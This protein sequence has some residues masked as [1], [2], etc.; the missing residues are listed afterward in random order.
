[1]SHNQN[2]GGRGPE[3]YLPPVKKVAGYAALCLLLVCF[4]GCSLFVMAG[5]AI[6]G[7]PQISSEFRVHTGID[8]TKGKDSVLILCSAPHG[9]LADFPALQIDIV[10]RVSR[11]LKTRNV[12]VIPADDVAAWYDSHGE[13][14][15]F[16]ALAREFK[17][18]YVMHIDLH[19]FTYRVPDSETV[20]QG[21]CQGR[22]KVYTAKE[23]T[24]GPIRQIFDR[25][26]K[27]AFPEAYPV[28]RENHSD[29][30]FGETFMDR[31]ALHIAQLIYDHRMAETV[32]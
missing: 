19:T 26:L 32:H 27:I 10:D 20:L 3:Q 5:K 23:S 7:D 2:N 22:V 13:W 6:L 14:G 4:S 29:S 1:M 31:V 16:S 9:I 28:P 21:N 18:S 30:V 12:N 15:D 17:A 8:L 25:S 24:D 11:T